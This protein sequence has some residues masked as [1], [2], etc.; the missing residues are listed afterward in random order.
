MWEE[1]NK[2]TWQV[3]PRGDIKFF[4]SLYTWRNMF[5]IC[6]VYIFRTR[7]RD[8]YKAQ[9]SQKYESEDSTCCDIVERG[10]RT[11]TRALENV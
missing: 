10:T 6:V 4:I 9:T 11:N 3:R 7:L 5:V 8:A 1:N 2:S